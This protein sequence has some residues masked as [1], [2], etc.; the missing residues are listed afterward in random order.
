MVKKRRENERQ[1]PIRRAGF[2]EPLESAAH[3]IGRGAETIPGHDASLG[4]RQERIR[5]ERR[6]L[7]EWAEEEGKLKGKLPIEHTR[8]GEHTV[9]VDVTKGRVIKA[10][11][12]D[13]NRGFGIAYGSHDQGATPSEYLDRLAAH[14][15]IF[16]DDI[17]LDRVVV[18]SPEAVS[19]VTSQ[20]LI[21]GRDATQEEIDGLMREK[22]FKRL[23]TGTYYHREL[24]LLIHDMLPKN[25]KVSEHD[26]IIH[27]IDPV[28]QR[29]TPE[30]AEYLR[31]NPIHGSP[32]SEPV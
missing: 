17:R 18:L 22:E 13:T 31:L 9:W 12:P 28:I 11:R 24:G 23:S 19:I 15:R 27:P 29:A 30:F 20:P 6:R 2:Q 25:V 3:D 16:G 4:E 5:I 7:K 21:Q 26:G 10:T 32:G 14:N 1:N 8:G